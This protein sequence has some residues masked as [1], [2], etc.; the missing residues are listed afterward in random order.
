LDAEMARQVLSDPVIQWEGN[1]WANQPAGPPPEN[2]QGCSYLPRTLMGRRQPAV[3]ENLVNQVTRRPWGEFVVIGKWPGITVK[4]IRVRA[5]HRLSLQKHSLRDEEW[6]CVKG[7]AVAQLDRE[8]HPLRAGSKVFIPRNRLHRLSTVSGAEVLEVGY[9]QFK[10]RD[11][12]RVE[13]D[14]G[15]ASRR[16]GR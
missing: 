3:Q 15:R 4:L 16:K 12:V 10:E 2:G 13:D 5:R 7:V 8:K 1:C 9:G 11:V 6:L 14:Y